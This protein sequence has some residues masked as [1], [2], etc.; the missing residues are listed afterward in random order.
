MA[1]QLDH[2]VDWL[3]VA[4]EQALRAA[5]A[6]ATPSATAGESPR[7]HARRRGR[8]GGQAPGGGGV[9]ERGD[10]GGRGQLALLLATVS[11]DGDRRACLAVVFGRSGGACA[12]R[13]QSTRR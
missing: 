8:C 6:A 13:R 7:G 4:P 9:G 10:G 1:L 3:Y 12:C 11:F 2:N 5:A